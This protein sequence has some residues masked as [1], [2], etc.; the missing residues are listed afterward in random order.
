MADYLAAAYLHERPA[1][2]DQDSFPGFTRGAQALARKDVETTSDA[3]FSGAEEVRSRGAVAFL[4]VV[5]PEGR[6]VGA[7]ARVFLDLAVTDGARDR[8]L[9]LRGRL[10]LT[11][12]GDGWQ[13][14]GYDL[15]LGASP[16]KGGRR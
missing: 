8:L 7:T 1:T 13:I 10:L 6:P 3:A 11:P 15:S 14:F 5:A 2:G 12:A 16:A 9:E 4:S